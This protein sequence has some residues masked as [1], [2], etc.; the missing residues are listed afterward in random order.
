VLDVWSFAAV[1]TKVALYLGVFT[2]AGTVFAAMALRLENT[3]NV[4]AFFAILGFVATILS[5]SLRGASL[6][7]DASGMID[8]EMLSLLWAT[9]V[10]TAFAYRS[11]GLV[12]LIAGL[13]IGRR[14]L[15]FSAFG[16]VVAVWSFNQVGH[17]SDRDIGLMNVALALHLLAVAFWVGI[18]IPLR[19]LASEPANITVAAQVGHRF[20]VIASFVVPALIIAGGYMAYTLLESFSAL[21][22][23][24]YGQALT[25]KV[26]L[27]SGLLVLAA[28]NKLR[29]IPRLRQGDPIAAG[30]LVRSISI[31]WMVIL[32]VFTVTAVLTSNLELPT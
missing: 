10:G 18:L 17:V 20:G 6:T 26:V 23:T 32:A 31:E 11:M 22:G 19:R 28:A 30:Q 25:L 4:A 3:R 13:L 29:F 21:M 8:P 27:V 1:I 14:G 16:G 9:P 7:G 5:F 2:A 15:W 12:V 24:G